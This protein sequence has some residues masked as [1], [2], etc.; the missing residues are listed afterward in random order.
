RDTLAYVRYNRGYKAFGFNV[1]TITP[2]PEAAPETVDDVEI[3][4][5]QS[6][7]RTF[8]YN[9]DFFYYNYNNDQVPIDIATSSLII[10]EFKNIPAAVSEGVELQMIWDPIR[11]LDF[12]FT[13]S[14]DD[15][16]VTSNCTSVNG[17]PTGTCIVDVVDPLAL[18]SGAKPVGNLMG[19]AFSQSIKGNELPQAPKNKI[20]FNA[21]YTWEFE[22]GNFTLSATY[23]WKDKSYSGIFTR[24]YDEAPSWNQVDARGTWSGDH[25]RYEV[26]FFVKNLFNTLGYDAAGG[27]T[28][29][30]TGNPAN[31]TFQQPSFDLTPPRTY[32]VEVHYKF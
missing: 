8:Q 5:K 21:N 13:Y 22:P 25:D 1:G 20:A 19:G 2:S 30:F 27:A 18:A 23:V 11:H 10:T 14:F 15:T 6:L 9:L 32:G 31:P 16:F 28:A 7:G 3:G 12:N 29:G 4:L 24:T 17:V 26:I